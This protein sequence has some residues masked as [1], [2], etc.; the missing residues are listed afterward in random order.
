MTSPHIRQPASVQRV[1]MT[2]LVALLPGIAAYVWQVGAG[3]LVNLV[4]ATVTALAAE[5][6]VLK[7]RKRPLLITLTDGSA[8][9]SAWLIALILP[10]IV[11]WWLT[12][13]AVLVAVGGAKHLYGGIGQNPFNPAMAAYCAM[14]VAY[15]AL[16]SQWPSVDGVDFATQLQLILG[17]SREIDGITGATALDTMR[18]GLRNQGDVHTILASNTFG[19]AGGRGWEWIAAGYLAGGIFLLARRVITW[20]LPLGFV[21]G[22]GVTAGVSWLIAPDSF[23]SPL[24]HLASGGA[25][26]AA[27]FIVTDP[28]T[29]ANSPLGKFI[30]A[31]GVGVIAWVIRTFGVYP[32][33]IAFAVLLMNIC[34][35]LINHATLPAPAPAGQRKDTRS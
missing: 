26:L 28:I 21:V 32:D 16:M 30:F 10:S 2:V 4:I 5:A 31:A 20:H 23:P 22:I 14:I 13:I 8:V 15:P 33:G 3:I 27:F 24:F 35:P 18:T 19:L 29:C 7:L 11:P 6:L 9:V 34:V 25:M 1:M 12:V 17:G